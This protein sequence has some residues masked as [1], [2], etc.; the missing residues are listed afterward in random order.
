MM[1]ALQSASHTATG[2][3]QAAA[4]CLIQC[5][6]WLLDCTSFV[7][8]IDVKMTISRQDYGGVHMGLLTCACDAC[9]KLRL[10]RED[11]EVSGTCMLRADAT[12]SDGK[13]AA[14]CM[15]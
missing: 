3:P 15:G 2:T 11:E 5:K 4:A 14:E 6:G 13:A 7:L 12:L 10:S 8:T 9:S 1:R